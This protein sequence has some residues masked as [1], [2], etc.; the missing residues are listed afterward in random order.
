M[1]VLFQYIT[2]ISSTLISTSISS[3]GPA[4]GPGVGLGRSGRYGGPG[5]G[6]GSGPVTAARHSGIVR[7]A[8]GMRRRLSGQRQS[9]PGTP[10]EA[11]PDVPDVRPPTARPPDRP[12]DR[13]T[14]RG[15]TDRSNRRPA[16]CAHQALVRQSEVPSGWLGHLA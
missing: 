14:D 12:P 7:A 8:I 1:T 15:S 13:P 5:G 2:S 10:R 3:I 11:A 16:Q 4:S 6:P 9:G